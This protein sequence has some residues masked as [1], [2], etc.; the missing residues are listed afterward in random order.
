MIVAGEE[1]PRRLLNEHFEATQGCRIYN[2]YGP[3]EGTVWSTVWPC[4]ED[5]RGRLPVGYPV[6]G[7]Q[8]YVVDHCGNPLPAGISGEI[9]VGGENL[10]N[11]YIGEPALTAA[12]FVPDCFSG[13]D[14]TRVYAT[15]DLGRWD[16]DGQ[17]ECLGRVDRQVKVAGRRVE[18][19]EVERRLLEVPTVGNAAVITRQQANGRLILDAAVVLSKEPGRDEERL[20]EADI[21]A[22]LSNW[23]PR[24]MM[25][26]RVV[27]MEE[28]P[29]TERGK[30]DRKA[31]IRRLEEGPECEERKTEGA[32]DE[33][34]AVVRSVYRHVL[35]LE[36][37]DV[38]DDFFA[39]GGDSLGLL[40]VHGRLRDLL[41]VEVPLSA[42]FDSSTALGTARILRQ[43]KSFGLDTRPCASVRP[44]QEDPKPSLCQARMWFLTQLEPESSAYHIPIGVAF[45]G[46]LDIAA[47]GRAI[48][49]VRP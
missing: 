8:A 29:L 7:V 34:E 15:G 26:R 22:S 9:Y 11:G 1:F 43:L 17:L 44:S 39:L 40:R 31:V 38:E 5:T 36:R 25:P 32:E 49:E 47:V 28:M 18:L 30:V 37:V 24:Y 4:Q 48:N 19:E 35:D 13:S 42:L 27:I 45:H 46:K 12:A 41:G 2:E 21:L 6:S 3:T 16:A 10:A 33:L 20:V 14:G 23:L